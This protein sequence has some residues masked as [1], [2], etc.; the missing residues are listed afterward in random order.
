M[1]KIRPHSNL[2][3]WRELGVCPNCS[4]DMPSI[5]VEYTG[6]DFRCETIPGKTQ[7]HMEP[8][9]KITISCIACDTSITSTNFNLIKKFWQGKSEK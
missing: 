5:K 4:F 1:N 3:N 9:P 2:Y 7:K 8:I 6:I